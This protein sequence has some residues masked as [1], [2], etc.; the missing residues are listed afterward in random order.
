MHLSSLTL[1][2]F[3]SFADTTVLNLEPGVT[4]VVGPNGSGKSNI[5]DAITWVMGAQ[6]PSALR[7]Q[8]MDDVIFAG[9]ESRTALGRAEVTL[10]IDNADGELPIDNAEVAITRRLYRAGDSEYLLNGTQCRLIDLQ[11]LLSDVG[12]GRQQHIIVAQG[13]I[14]HALNAS[15]QER[16]AIVEEAAGILKFRRRKERA[17]RRLAATQD[18]VARLGD[19]QRELKRQLRPL[20]RQAEGAKK[21]VNLTQDFEALRLYDAG[22]R[23]F[24]LQTGLEKILTQKAEL[25]IE[26][27]T[28]RALVDELREAIATAENDLL[29]MSAM[30]QVELPRTNGTS[31]TSTSTDNTSTDNTSNTSTSNASTSN[32]TG[33]TNASTHGGEHRGEHGGEHRGKAAEVSLARVM[34]LA[35]RA[36][37]LLGQ[38]HERLRSTK[39]D[40]GAVLAKDVA[41]NYSEEQSRI[42]TE[43]AALEPQRAAIAQEL[44]SVRAHLAST[45]ETGSAQPDPAIASP[46]ATGPGSATP[47]STIPA[48]VDQALI[49]A[50]E[51]AAS[52]LTTA[53][54]SL[55]TKT[56]AFREIGEELQH[57]TGR[58][59][60]LRLALDQA[61][62]SSGIAALQDAEGV[63]GILADLI[64]VEAGAERATKAAI[65]ESLSAVVVQ[66]ESQAHAAM[67]ALANSDTTGTVLVLPETTSDAA[68]ASRTAMTN[69]PAAAVNPAALSDIATAKPLRH[70]V[71]AADPTNAQLFVSLLDALFDGIYLVEGDW[72]DAVRAAL[73]HPKLTFVTARGDRCGS[74][75]WRIGAST[76][77]VTTTALTEAER[78]IKKL[79]NDLDTARLT[80]T[81]ARD[82]HQAATQAFSESQAA[83]TRAAQATAAAL[84]DRI[85]QL[86]EQEA[87]LTERD[88]ALARRQS[89]LLKRN[90]DISARLTGH[91][92]AM[93]QADR[94]QDRLNALTTGLSVLID[95]LAATTNR[96]DSAV[97]LLRRRDADR[98]EQIRQLQKRLDS[99]RREI[100]ATQAELAELGT[101][102]TSLDVD[103]SALNTKLELLETSLIEELETD[104]AT[105]LAA[106][107]PRIEPGFTFKQRLKQVRDELKRMGPVNPL[108]LSEFEA[109]TERYEFVEGQMKDVRQSRRELNKVVKTIE[110]EIEKMFAAAFTDVQKT[111]GRLFETLFPGGTGKLQ[112]TDPNSEN[113]NNALG[114]TAVGADSAEAD[115]NIAVTVADAGAL[116]GSFKRSSKNATIAPFSGIDLDVR[117]SGRRVSRLSLLSGGERSLTALAFLFAVF[118]SR[119]S[120]FYILDEVEAALDDINLSR[121]LNLVSE[122]RNEVQLV[123]VTHQQ[124]TMEFA[125]VM[126]GVSMPPGGSSTVIAERINKRASASASPSPTASPVPAGVHAPV[127]D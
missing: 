49:A 16:R 119:P 118:R 106:P 92:E 54:Q 23:L 100:S 80:Q 86:S 104:A 57:W 123:I 6:G 43:L 10:V 122:F 127:A 31:D 87:A 120:P 42:T 108:A 59:D 97:Q 36:R 84:A 51:T 76:D 2:G 64:D 48:P 52:N 95:W 65:G 62:Q 61:R 71:S 68:T 115:P 85:R 33:D 22:Q 81:H 121:F 9:T 44:E 28:K 4:T 24:S 26:I 126:Y 8:K 88:K 105:V 111:F 20:R 98:Y 25:T 91:D 58:A 116:T 102:N 79:R 40:R 17:E 11:E 66:G 12:V 77:A 15:P 27:A 89:E 90:Q 47:G 14:E 34:A 3:K 5:V 112:L 96:L 63:V 13:Q 109:L 32:T 29:K 69:D 45:S 117:P 19:L 78:N 72:R 60:A 114:N 18:N 110:A 55:A 7:S 101:T 125:D 41:A 37:G 113:L 21:H 93:V 75:G 50:V 124:R 82:Q 39:R 30:P 103:Q 56:E 107:Q 1:K 46:A 99:Q 38:V 67:S 53:E 35:E 70:F 73:A 83:L 94:M 74:A